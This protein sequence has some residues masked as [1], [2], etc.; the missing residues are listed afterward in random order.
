DRRHARRRDRPVRSTSLR[1]PGPGLD[2][3]R[4]LHREPPDE[5]PDHGGHGERRRRLRPDRRRPPPGAAGPPRP[6]RPGRQARGPRGRGGVGRRRHA[7]RRGPARR[8]AGTPPPAH[9]G[10]GRPDPPRDRAAPPR[11]PSRRGRAAPPPRRGRPVVRGRR[12]TRAG[13][14][15]GGRPPMSE[16][17]A[18]AAAVLSGNDRGGYTVPTARLYP[19]Q[20][21]WDSGLVALGWATL[22]EPR[23]WQELDRLFEGQWPDGMLPHIVFHQD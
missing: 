19:F 18:R 11:R 20:W 9:G 21:N 22:S 5:L 16:L 15:L 10:R 6:R 7:R 13:R 4:E 12:G 2:V 1:L 17:R 14:R 3:R 23:A 8:A